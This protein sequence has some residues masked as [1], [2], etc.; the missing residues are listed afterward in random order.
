MKPFPLSTRSVALVPLLAAIALAGCGGGGGGSKALTPAEKSAKAFKNANVEGSFDTPDKAL[1]RATRPPTTVSI[2]FAN[3]NTSGSGV[4]SFLTGTAADA[5]TFAAYSADVS[6]LEFTPTTNAGG[7]GTISGTVRFTLSNFTD[8]KYFAGT[9]GF[10]G[11]YTLDTSTLRPTLTG[12]ITG[13]DAKGAT[14][15]ASVALNYQLGAANIDLSGTYGGQASYTVAPLPSIK[16]F[17][18]ANATLA[19]V[20][21]DGLHLNGTIPFTPPGSTVPTSLTFNGAYTRTSLSGATVIPA[22]IESN[23]LTIPKGSVA[24]VYLTSTDSGKTIKGSLLA[25]VAGIGNVVLDLSGTKGATTGG[26]G[27]GTTTNLKTGYYD[28]G[29]KAANGALDGRILRLNVVKNS[30]T[31]GANGAAVIVYGSSYGYPNVGGRIASVTGSGND[32]TITIDNL[33]ANYKTFVVK[34][35]L[36]G[37]GFS[38]ASFTGTTLDGGTETG[39]IDQLGQG[40]TT[41]KDFSGTFRGTL[42]GKNGTANGFTGLFTPKGDGT[43]TITTTSTLGGFPLPPITAYV[44]GDSF[45][46]ADLSSSLPS[47]FTGASFRGEFSGTLSGTSLAGLFAYSV[48]NGTTTLASDKGAL[49]LTKL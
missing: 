6:G 29:V 34:G 5:T 7:V 17:E 12:T 4:A 10:S 23:G 46:G 21:G 20:S 1:A 16:L 31:T 9:A 37:S 25:T 32:V 15:T 19:K 38:A 3:D 40:T 28:G 44:A 41:T 39:S 33:T 14:T 13:K 36:S 8:N 24:Q 49:S 35:T 42:T 27:G 45:A 11:T 43:V 2:Q 18:F 30:P 26:G 47:P 48:V 22:N